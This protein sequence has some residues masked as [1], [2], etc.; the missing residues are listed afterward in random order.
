[1]LWNQYGTASKEDETKIAEIE[2]KAR[3]VFSEFIDKRRSQDWRISW[4]GK[5]VRKL[6]KDSEKPIRLDQYS[7]IYSYFSEFSHSNPLSTM[8]TMSLG[9]T[10]EETEKLLQN[11]EETEKTGLTKVLTLST[12]WLL[13]ILSIGK[14]E[15]PL[16][17]LKWNF[18]VL[19]KIFKII[20]AKPPKLSFF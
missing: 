18:D 15:I 12:N 6:A 10:L 17:D 16:Y 1:M 13:E 19:R 20:G 2:N 3:F 4:C 14:S 7:L 9:S 11:K 8:T 5:S